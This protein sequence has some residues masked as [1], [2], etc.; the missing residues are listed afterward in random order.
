[1]KR[2]KI[3]IA[4]A[5]TS[6]EIFHSLLPFIRLSYSENEFDIKFLDHKIFN[7]NNYQA[8]LLI[9]VRKYQYFDPA[10]GPNQKAI[11]SEL[12]DYRKNYSKIVISMIMRP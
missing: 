11:I 3:I 10:T 4:H 2:Q 12:K 9:I 5:H 8:D 1:M 7:L 6:I